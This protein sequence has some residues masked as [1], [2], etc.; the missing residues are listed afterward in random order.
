[1]PETTR[2]AADELERKRAKKKLALLEREHARLGADIRAAGLL[3]P[4]A[5]K[6]ARALTVIEGGRD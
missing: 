6:R 2:H 1:M 5:S 4:E 3:A